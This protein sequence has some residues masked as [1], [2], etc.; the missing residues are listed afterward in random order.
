MNVVNKVKVGISEYWRPMRPKEPTPP[1]V[2]RDRR[3]SMHTLT[4]QNIDVF[5][6]KLAEHVRQGINQGR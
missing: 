6:R 5:T 1:W 2:R 4:P 3:P